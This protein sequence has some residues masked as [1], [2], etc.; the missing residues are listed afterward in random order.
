[1]SN[2]GD[3]PTGLSDAQTILDS[4]TDAFFSLNA[5]WEFSYVNRRTEEV[6][7]HS[8]SE[9]LGKTLWAVFPGT[10]GS[11][12]ERMYRKPFADG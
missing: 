4:I 6:L 11:E 7:G 2:P 8:A 10:V 9:L 3:Q 12:F 5:D 1:M